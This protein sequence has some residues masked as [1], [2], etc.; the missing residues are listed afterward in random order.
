M[1]EKELLSPNEEISE[2]ATGES[3][4]SNLEQNVNSL[5]QVDSTQ[6]I[7]DSHQHTKE[8]ESKNTAMQWQCPICGETIAHK[9]NKSRHVKAC[10]KREN[11]PK[12]FKCE[13]CESDFPNK[14]NLRR[15]LVEVHK[16]VIDGKYKCS[17]ENCEYSTDFEGQF[18]K[19]MT[20]FHFTGPKIEYFCDLCD[21]KAQSESGLKKHKQ[22]AH[23]FTSQK[24]I[25]CNIVFMSKKLYRIHMFKN[26]KENEQSLTENEQSVTEQILTDVI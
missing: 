3:I 8:Q 13:K 11:M 18:K 5:D 16:V 9:K 25:L 26:H 1:A 19:H 14:Q 15:H 17:A 21:Y 7:H 6:S 20:M 12:T 10:N 24:C 23:N 22:K 2:T 4:F